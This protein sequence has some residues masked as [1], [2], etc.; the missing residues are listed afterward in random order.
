M[1]EHPISFLAISSEDISEEPLIVEAE[2]EGYLVRRV[3]VDEGSSVEVMFEHCFENL[4]SRIKARLKETQTD[5]VG[6]EGEISKP[7]GKIELEVCFDNRGLCRRTSMKFIVVRV[8]SP[9]NIIL[10][11]PRLKTLR[12]IPSTIHSMMKF[13]T[14]K[15]MATLVT[16]TIIIAECGRLEK[17]QMIKEESFEREKEV[18]VTKEV[19]VNPSFSDQRVTIGRRLSKACRDQLKCLLKDKMRVFAWEPSDMTG[20]PRRIIEH[21]LN[22]NPSL[23]PVCQKRRTFSL[24]K[25]GVIAN[26]V[27]E[28][29]KTGIVCPVSLP[30]RLLSPSQHRLQG[31]VGDGIQIQVFSGCLQGLSSNLNGRRIRRKDDIL[32]RS[33]DILLY[34]NALRAEKCKGYIPKLKRESFLRYMV[35]SKEVRANPK[36]TKALADLQ[37]PRTLKEMQSLSGKLASLNRF[38]SKPA[39]RSLPFVNTLKNITKENKHEYRWTKEAEEAFQQMKKLILDLPS[40][41]PPWPKETLYAYLAVSA[42][43]VSAVLLTDRK[44]RQCPVQYVSR[45]LNEAERNYAPMEK[46]ALSL[47]HMTRILRRYFEA[48]PMKLAKYA[49]EI[50]AYSITFMPRNAVKGQVLADFLSEAPER[51]KEESYFRMPEVPVEKDDMEIWILFTNGASSPKG[52]G[53]EVKVDS[54]LVASQINGSYEASKDNMIKYLAKAKEYASGFKSFSIENILRNMNQKADLLSKLVSV[55]F[56]HLTKEVLVEVLNEWST[57][58][59]EIHAIVEE[60]GDSWMTPI[61]R[62]LEE[63]VWPEDKNK[64]RCLPAKIG[65]YT[66]E[67]EILFKKGYLVPMLRCVG[68]LQQTMSYA[69]F[70]WDLTVPHDVVKLILFLFSLKGAA[71]SWLENEPPNSITT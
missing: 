49:V 21:M 18:A 10:G 34:K 17:K 62:C 1:D 37:S 50:G 65:Q 2:V 25:S 43:A 40:L 32:H 52:S 39:E 27:A 64:A 71:E 68:P 5:L 22:V 55:A 36:K 28:W 6:F 58:G 35:T 57:E 20:L 69:R 33:R 67:S 15:G 3:Y 44:G 46:L 24:E 30:K 11:R 61:I 7:L 26:E 59:Q 19:L 63:E 8:P 48:H 56:N 42:E 70:T 12:T 47:I 14:P 29:V 45:T 38:L 23:D 13:P 9:Y 51:E 54:K 41:T 53:A 60:E 66:M 16:Q 31:R 4:D